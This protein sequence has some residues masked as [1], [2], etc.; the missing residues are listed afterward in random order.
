[1]HRVE[2]F[3]LTYLLTCIRKRSKLVSRPALKFSVN[4]SSKRVSFHFA[5]PQS[6]RK[7][8]L[9]I[10]ATLTLGRAGIRITFG[11]RERNYV[12]DCHRHVCHI[13][14]GQRRLERMGSVGFGAWRFVNPARCDSGQ[15]RHRLT[16]ASDG[17]IQQLHGERSKSS[18]IPSHPCHNVFSPFQQSPGYNCNFYFYCLR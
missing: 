2:I 7:R 9:S 1:M 15:Q 17:A 4:C 8:S 18:L 16:I 3:V 12:A 5:H 11:L 6:T 14:S 13:N 10:A